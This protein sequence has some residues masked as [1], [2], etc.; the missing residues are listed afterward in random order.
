MGWLER[1]HARSPRAILLLGFGAFLI[2][3]FPGYMST[4]S[5]FQLVEART[6]DFSDGHPPLMAVQWAVFDRIVSGPVLMLLAQGLMF[7]AGVYLLLRRVM[8]PRTAAWVANA[9]L[10]FPPVMVPMAV[11]WKDSQMAAYL[12]LGAGLMLHERVRVRFLGLGCL[13]VACALRHNAFAAVVPLVFFLFEW[14]P[15]IRWW[16]RAAVL[17]GATVIMI[18]TAYALTRVLAVQHVRL[19]PVFKDIVGVIARSDVRSDE[20]WR[21]VLR[22]TPLV[23]TTGIQERAK[24]LHAMNGAFHIVTGPNRLFDNPRT[25]EHWVALER[26]WKELALGDPVAYFLSHWD[27]MAVAMGLGP[28]PRM[29]NP[30]WN[31]FL[32]EPGTMLE[33]HHGANWSRAQYELG[34]ALNW[35]HEHTSLYAPYIYALIALLLL[36][37]CARDRV[38]I[39]LLT[40]GLLYELSFFPAGINADY[41]YS[42]W[43]ITSTC[44]AVA[45][46]FAQRLRRAA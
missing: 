45:M 15:G 37:L 21:H 30:V 17:G 31:L 43:M 25:P 42:H 1:L 33:I 5:T 41:R 38:T 9:V 32:E 16:K 11:I 7:L 46:L 14:R 2:Y 19:T 22:D 12:V 23:G 18:L 24:K 4:D 36:A 8:T 40:S 3:A 28:D 27:V 44:I 20:E 10:L 29:P 13:F 35:L 34:R 39:G 26:A 6:L